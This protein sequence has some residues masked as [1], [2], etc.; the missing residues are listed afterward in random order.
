MHFYLGHRLRSDRRPYNT[1]V[2][3]C[4]WFFILAPFTALIMVGITSV[5]LMFAVMFICVLWPTLPTFFQA[6]YR[7]SARR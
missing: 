1:E 2:L 6:R 3:I 5:S 4:F 7:Q